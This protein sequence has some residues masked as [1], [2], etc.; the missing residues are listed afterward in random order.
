MTCE[1]LNV[2]LD[3]LMDGEL[4]EDERRA[5]DAHGAECPECAGQIRATLQMKAL[6]EEMEP[7]VDVPLAA[8]AGWRSAIRQEAEAS[9]EAQKPKRADRRRLIRWIGSAA[10]AV[11]VL[12][13]VGLALNG[14][15]SPRKSNDVAMLAKA[16][17]GTA[18]EI[19]VEPDAVPEVGVIET[20]G[21]N[22][23]YEAEAE[24]EAEAATVTDAAV[25]DDADAASPVYEAE[26]AYEADAAEADFATVTDA[27]SEA[28]VA[29]EANVAGE[30]EAYEA[31]AFD[32][33][34]DMG[35]RAVA[36]EPMEAA[37]EEAPMMAMES[38]PAKCAA[39]AQQAPACELSIRVPDVQDACGVISDL[40][41]EFEGSA[42]VQSVEGGSANVYV[43]LYGRNAADFLMAVAKLDTSESGV[44]LPAVSEEGSLLVLLVVEP[45]E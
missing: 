11:V 43:T 22:A 12:V 5:L 29:T 15:L 24:Y 30:A 21:E 44:D 6:F 3:R 31:E 16:A 2:L 10:A 27:A 1:E 14:S 42:D 41:G 17:G 35:E 32:A 37:E 7:E 23:V 39:L 19:A 40:A 38:A 36:A 34:E 9:R 26:A 8:Q 18:A 33:A 4:T 45:E 25:T 28:N 13:G 20:D